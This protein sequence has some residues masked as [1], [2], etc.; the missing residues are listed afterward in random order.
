MDKFAY[1]SDVK[2]TKGGISIPP[3]SLHKLDQ[4]SLDQAIKNKV[5]RLIKEEGKNVS[6]KKRKGSSIGGDNA[7]D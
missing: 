7:K 5:I 6:K 3:E 2:L 4:R 1:I